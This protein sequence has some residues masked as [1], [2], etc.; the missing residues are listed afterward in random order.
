MK[1]LEPQAVQV[2]ADLQ[3]AVGGSVLLAQA[4]VRRGVTTPAAAR[5]FLD[6][7]S[8]TLAS[9]LELPDMAAAVERLQ[10]AIARSERILVWGDFDTDGVT[11]TALLVEAL[12]ALGAT[13]DWYIPDR[14]SESH[15]VHW[16]SLQP[17]LGRGTRV[18]LTCDTGVSAHEAL[19][20][21]RNAGLDVVVTDHHQLPPALPPAQAIVNPNRLPP[22][23]PLHGLSG[24]GVAFEL[25]QALGAPERGL[26]LVG[27]GMIADLVPLQGD[28]RP[29]VQRGL[30][31]LRHPER[32]GLQAL[33]EVAELDALTL[34]EEDVSF[35]LAPRLNALGRLADA[36]AGVELFLTADLA[37]ARTIAAD[38]E[39]LNVRRQFLSRQVTAA[40]QGL[41]ERDRTLLSRAVLVLSHPDWPGGLLGIA[42]SHLAGRYE[43]PVVLI[44]TPPGERARG[45]AR[46]I[47]GVDIYAALAAQRELL[48]SFGGHPM[49]AGFAI[50]TERIPDL[51]HGLALVVAAQVGEALPER[52][53]AIEGYFSLPQLSLELFDELARL[54]PFGPG[55]PP[56]TLATTRLRVAN[57]RTIGRTAEHRRLELQD[58][59][60][61]AMPA[62]WWQSADLPVPE[63]LFDLAYV[64]HAS[65]F[66]GE[67]RLEL[68]W[69]D[70]RWME[71]PPVELAVPTPLAQ[72]A[73]YRAAAAPEAALRA[74][75]DAPAMQ[76]WA[77]VVLPLGFP[78]RDRQGLQAGPALVVWTLPPGPRVW[79][80]A[81][82]RVA[83]GQVY[84]FAVDP[85]LDAL[86]PFLRRLAG[87]VKHALSA[88]NGRLEW[89]ALAAAMAHRVET[90]QAGLRWLI[91]HGTVCLV[92]REEGAVIVEGGGAE[93]AAAEGTARA[94]L[95]GLLR[96]TAAYRAYFRTAETR[97]LLG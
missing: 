67:R 40:A 13:V 14:R 50:L 12:R 91:A 6:P 84:L 55:N 77:E 5:A 47:P 1:W 23:H 10:A 38:M 43:R 69:V 48:T 7:A 78:S 41:V 28:V 3:T 35:A 24:V 33:L 25:A 88:Y 62:L 90:V 26:D 36:S 63:G 32:L 44:A 31:A 66:A 52:E 2:P 4:L 65:E 37:R 19:S 75:W 27:L 21:A 17:F 58:E 15:G 72:V 74:L 8:Y 16:R 97:A 92:A 39:A 87:L 73:D 49:A 70:A 71:R 20:L 56:L 68:E 86:D 59:Q 53:L 54:A 46:S 95:A 61:N 60:G 85:G 80:D 81:L 83:P 82:R 29:L 89:R 30:A 93:D 79:Q 64:L 96:E 9:P 34:D 51:R 18:L 57:H 22:E 11:S 94:A 76:L 42:A 45:S